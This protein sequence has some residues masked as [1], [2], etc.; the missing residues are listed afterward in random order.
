MLTMDS[1]NTVTYLTGHFQRPQHRSTLAFFYCDFRRP[2]TQ[3]LLN[4]VGSL[5]AQICSQR[6][7]FPSVVEQAFDHSHNG[8]G[9]K[10]RPSLALLR[11]LLDLSATQSNLTLLIDAIDE[12]QQRQELFDFFSELQSSSTNIRV[13][14]TSREEAEIQYGLHSFEHLRIEGHL[15]EV[16]NDVRAYIANRLASD[17]KLQWLNDSVKDDIANLLMEKSAGM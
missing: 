10:K 3:D 7:I 9:Q 12:C 4:V 11:E 14:L 8:P 5:V 13:M 15:T 17:R 6:G 16:N 2:E 1:S